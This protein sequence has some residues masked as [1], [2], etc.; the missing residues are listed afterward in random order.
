MFGLRKSLRG[1]PLSTF[2][3]IAVLPPLVAT[4][5]AAEAAA[6]DGAPTGS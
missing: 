6:D 3:V 1:K 4:G 2:V 5:L